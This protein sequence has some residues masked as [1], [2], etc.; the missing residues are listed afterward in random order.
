[1]PGVSGRRGGIV[2]GVALS[3][4]LLGFAGPVEAQLLGGSSATT[5]TLPMRATTTTEQPTTTTEPRTTTTGAEPARPTA[6]PTTRRPPTTSSAPERTTTSLATSTSTSLDLSLSPDLLFDRS[7]ASTTSTF[8]ARQAVSTS[9]P[10]TGSLVALV[11]SGLL[12]VALALSFLTVRYW[13]ATRPGGGQP[14]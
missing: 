12:G 6:P 3:V 10:G 5:T 13:R 9:R 14:G 4:G 11:I 1:M 7:T 8:P 2:A